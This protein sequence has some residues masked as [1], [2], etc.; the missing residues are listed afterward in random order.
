[1]QMLK[2]KTANTKL[3]A[4]KT[5]L[6]TTSMIGLSVGAQ[7][8]GLP[9]SITLSALDGTDGYIISGNVTG[10][11]ANTTGIGDFNGDGF[12]DVLITFS[13]GDMTIPDPNN[14]NDPNFN[15]ERTNGAGYVVFGSNDPS[16]TFDLNALDGTNGF[17]IPS[18]GGQDFPSNMGESIGSGDFNNDGLEDIIIGAQTFG[19]FD[20]RGYVLF[21]TTTPDAVFDTRSLDGT[22]GFYIDESPNNDQSYMGT[23]VANAGDVN[24]DGIDDIII[25]ATRTDNSFLSNAGSANIIFGQNTF[26]STVYTSTLDGTDGFRVLGEDFS[27]RIGRGVSSAGDMNGDGIDDFIIGSPEVNGNKG[28]VY[29]VYGTDQGFTAELLPSQLDGTNGFILDGTNLA[30]NFAGAYVTELG[31]VNNDGYDDIGIG[32]FDLRVGDSDLLGSP[33]DTYVIYGGSNISNSV[34]LSTLDGTNGTTVTG[35]F[36]LFSAGDLNADGFDDIATV[37]GNVIFGSN[38]FGANLDASDTLSYDGLA[39]GTSLSGNRGGLGGFDFNNDGIEDLVVPD[40][41]NNGNGANAYIVFGASDDPLP[42]EVPA[43]AALPLLALG[44]FGMTRLRRRS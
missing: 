6:L 23:S 13:S 35:A 31:D 26:S 37:G 11:T 18:E 34:D 12:D 14:P 40:R 10:A 5:A 38:S 4:F 42:P 24:N 28:E 32:A 17:R 22:N 9:D 29:V 21:G 8:Q 39:L 20:G 2:K 41:A 7:A 3:S 44:L 36:N 30:Q 27:E 1:M 16:A 33:F 25:S 43:P 15:Q 19:A